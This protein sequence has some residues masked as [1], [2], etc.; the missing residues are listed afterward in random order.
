[1]G[2]VAN[3]SPSALPISTATQT[4]LN[5]INTTIATLA[6]LSGG[7]ITQAGYLQATFSVSCTS[8][9][10]NG[11]GNA[12]IQGDVLYGVGPT[13]LTTQMATINDYKS[14]G[15]IAATTTFQTIYTPTSGKQGIITV[16]STSGSYPSMM[17]AFFQ[18]TS[19]ATVPSLT[20]IASSGNA[21]QS[22]INTTNV[23]AGTQ[24]IAMQMLQT[25]IP[26]IQVKTTSGAFTVNWLVTL[27]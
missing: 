18:W 17:A 5:S 23:G 22:A 13:S 11:N 16:V 20:Q 21:T 8:L 1:M 3:T 10:V 27:M 2:N 9:Y 26:Y 15:T 7:N 12:T 19:G 24:F 25:G 6:P 14:N 4:A